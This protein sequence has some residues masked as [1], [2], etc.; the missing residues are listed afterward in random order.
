MNRL[1]TERPPES[2]YYYEQEIKKQ[3]KS[4]E[5]LKSYD[6]DS[7]KET[8][9]EYDRILREMGNDILETV[10]QIESL[11]NKPFDVIK[12]SDDD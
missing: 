9:G 11:K 12:I 10:S 8:K 3:N 7:Y 1:C 4:H 2:L 5:G 6:F